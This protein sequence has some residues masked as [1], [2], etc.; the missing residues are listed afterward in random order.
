M[1]GDQ[2]RHGQQVRAGEDRRA[3]TARP[4]AANASASRLRLTASASATNA[5][6][7]Q[8][9]AQ[10]L[11]ELVAGGADQRRVGADD[12]RRRARPAH[13][14]TRIQASAAASAVVPVVISA[15]CQ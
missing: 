15:C 1:P 6:E 3:R 7:Q 2:E 10:R 8:E 14:P 5:A 11:G 9:R 4:A 13:G 12:Q